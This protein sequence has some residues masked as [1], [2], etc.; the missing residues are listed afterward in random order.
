MRRLLAFAAILAVALPFL[1]PRAEAQIAFMPYLGYDFEVAD[2]A[3]LL[4]VGAEF[5]I[6]PGALPVGL[7]LRP[8]AEYYF[9]DIDGFS[10]FQ[11]NADVI[12]TFTPPLANI[13]VYGGAG[14]AMG[15]SSFEFMGES[16]SDTDFGLNLLGGV[17]IGSGFVVP[18]VQGRMTMMENS[19]FGIQGGVRLG[20]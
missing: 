20:L 10:F 5:G 15:F 9:T 16:Q 13:G 19:R 14:L 17:T 1:A 11:V 4:G 7:A 18:F 3:L 8:A 6:L 12:A 2:G